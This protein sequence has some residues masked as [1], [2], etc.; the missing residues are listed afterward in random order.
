MNP[1]A[2]CD[3]GQN[4]LNLA[5]LV[6]TQANKLVIQSNGFQRFQKQR[7]ASAA[8][9]MDH[10]VNPTLLSRYYRNNIAVLANGDEILLQGSVV[11]VRANKLLE[12]FLNALLLLC[13]VAPNT[14]ECN[15]GLIR[16]G[17]VGKKCLSVSSCQIA[18]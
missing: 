1:Q 5:Q 18:Q 3:L 12:R 10:S 9:A 11:A 15:T 8:G 4:S 2:A 17:A 14:A 13:D 6:L 16:Q 7:A